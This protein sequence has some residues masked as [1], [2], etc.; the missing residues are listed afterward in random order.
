M[1]TGSI[2]ALA[3]PMYEDGQIDWASLDALIEFQIA[4]GTDA[5]VTVG[6]T[7]ESATLNTAEHCRVIAH[8]VKKISGRI[9]VIAGTGSNSTS[10]A[11]ELTQEAKSLG[12]DACLLVTPYYNKPTQH[13][14]YLHHEAIAKAVDIGQILYN[15]PGRT[16]VNLLP[17]TIA[18]IAEIDQIIGVKEAT[19]D[20]Q[21]GKKVIDLVGDKIAVYSGD[22]ETAYKLML[23]G[24]KGNISVTANILPKHMSELCKLA[25]SEKNF[26]AEQLNN[27]L[28]MMHHAMF[29]ES[30]PIPVKWALHKMGYMT[31]GIRL[32]LTP[33]DQSN[34]DIVE[35][36]LHS[37]KL[38]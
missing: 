26:E 29:V 19:G 23:L 15:V 33:L 36:A 32:P 17:E 11:I 18:R 10:E 16:A 28:M 37:F 31:S 12:V 30:N 20:I 7:G 24:A 9:P 27:Q 6:T 14:L 22:D 13:G 1:I 4:N 21:I 2:V 8:T 38:V 3:T 35:Q 34:Q 5:I 25:L